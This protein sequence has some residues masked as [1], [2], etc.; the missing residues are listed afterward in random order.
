MDQ[1]I[2]IY[3]VGGAALLIGVIAGKFIFAKNTQ[4]KVD[5]AEQQAKKIIS[6]A[7]INA[8]NQKN[9]KHEKIYLPPCITL[10]TGC[11]HDGPGKSGPGHDQKNP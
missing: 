7:Q 10:R 6:D 3:I 2:L 5:A 4:Q 1:N 9:Q 11:Q 8:E